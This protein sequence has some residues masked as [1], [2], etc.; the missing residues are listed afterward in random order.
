MLFVAIA[1]DKPD[2]IQLRLDT[3]PAHLAYLA[4]I[5]ATLRLAGPFL[6]AD[7]QT[8]IGSLMVYDCADEAAAREV[9]DNDPFS[10]AMLFKSVEIKPWR[11]GAGTAIA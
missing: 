6:G 7:N 1:M 5:G 11:Q 4:K 3:R 8:A 10:K 9:V 2:S